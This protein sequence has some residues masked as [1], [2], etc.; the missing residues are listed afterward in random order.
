VLGEDDVPKVLAGRFTSMLAQLRSL[1]DK[2]RDGKVSRA[3]FVD[4]PT[5][6]FDRVD[7]NHDGVI[8]ADE[9][10]AARRQLAAAGR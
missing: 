3:E 2:D 7:T 8:A 5:P 10:A 6:V 9:L 4:G 1:F